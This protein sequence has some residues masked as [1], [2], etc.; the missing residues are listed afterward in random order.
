MSQA[1]L[2]RVARELGI[3]AVVPEG[4]LLDAAR[5]AA[6]KVERKAAPLTTYLIGVAAAQDPAKGEELCRRVIDLARSWE[7]ENTR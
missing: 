3:P 2:E 7:E 4:P 5:V 1:W 6:H